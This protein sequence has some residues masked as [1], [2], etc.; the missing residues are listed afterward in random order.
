MKFVDL[1][2]EESARTASPVVERTSTPT[3]TAESSGHRVF[4]TPATSETVSS[5]LPEAEEFVRTPSSSSADSEE[6]TPEPE[7]AP[8]PV[9]E[10]IT[11]AAIAMNAMDDYLKV[12][13]TN[14]EEVIEFISSIGSEIKKVEESGTE[15]E[16]AALAEKKKQLGVK[17]GEIAFTYNPEVPFGANWEER[18]AQ[19]EGAIKTYFEGLS[20]DEKKA[21]IASVEERDQKT[22]EEHEGAGEPHVYY[23]DRL[24]KVAGLVV[25]SES[26]AELV[27]EEETPVE[28]TVLEPEVVIV[29]PAE[30]ES[31]AMDETEDVVELDIVEDPEVSF[32]QIRAGLQAEQAEIMAEMELATL[33]LDPAEKQPLISEIDKRIDAL[34]KKYDET[35][36]K[37]EGKEAQ[38]IARDFDD[39]WEA[40]NV[41]RKKLDESLN[42]S[43]EEKSAVDLIARMDGKPD[44]FNQEC[45]QLLDRMK[46]GEITTLDEYICAKSV[47][48][49][50]RD[51]LN[52]KMSTLTERADGGVE[53]QSTP[54]LDEIN[55]TW[56]AFEIEYEALRR[57]IGAEERERNER[58]SEEQAET[59]PENGEPVISDDK[60][61]ETKKSEQ[62]SEDFA[63]DVVD[64][65]VELARTKKAHGKTLSELA[66]ETVTVGG[67]TFT[68]VEYYAACAE[69]YNQTHEMNGAAKESAY[70]KIMKEILGIE[71]VER[72][73]YYV[74]GNNGK[75]RRT[76]FG[77]FLNAIREVESS[78]IDRESEGVLDPAEKA[79]EKHERVGA[80]AARLREGVAATKEHPE[81]SAV[82]FVEYV[83]EI[84]EESKKK[85]ADA[86]KKKNEAESGDERV[87]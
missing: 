34:K 33:I 22:K 69:A 6:S 14:T 15:E 27:I 47:L 5:I 18:C 83:A 76:E 73:P 10:P 77:N 2:T 79:K 51:E 12:E 75:R 1:F 46:K 64:V 21:V 31:P 25:A 50:A 30:E 61:P 71:G 78:R 52:R 29:D 11:P 7:A 13:P 26:S 82:D 53:V 16:K 36:K 70:A 35:L 80:F 85:K 62:S 38:V 23:A 66:E 57:A 87:S 49:I 54:E 72:E 4:E 45:S 59:Q 60:K 3:S 58:E 44:V 56:N 32:D 55:D 74:T 28:V 84:G 63:E 67:K 48:Q 42:L 43:P 81:I 37:C 24:R 20:E 9:V 40:Y 68:K 8:A 65:S 39:Y 17:L 86:L 19:V 41:S